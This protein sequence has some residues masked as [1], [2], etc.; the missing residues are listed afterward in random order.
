MAQAIHEA[1][2]AYYRWRLGLVW[3]HVIATFINHGAGPDGSNADN[4]PGPSTYSQHSQQQQQRRLC[5]VPEAFSLPSLYV[6]ASSPYF[7]AQQG[8]PT[9]W[10]T[11]EM[12]LHHLC[13]RTV[14][15]S[16]GSG[17]VRRLPVSHCLELLQ[18]LRHELHA[19]QQLMPE[20]SALSDLDGRLGSL[21]QRCS[22]NEGQGSAGPQG[23]AAAA[24]AAAASPGRRKSSGKFY[25][26]SLFAK[27]KF[28]FTIVQQSA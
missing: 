13:G 20:C 22:T 26:V 11:A 10:P 5:G 1:S 3:M 6:A 8:L 16:S 12:L 21:L 17:G 14:G 24:A 15:S 28:I 18:Q 7:W 19:T 4:Q 25:L 27:L 2:R 9:Q 23:D